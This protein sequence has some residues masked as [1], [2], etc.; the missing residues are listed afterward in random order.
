MS[1]HGQLLHRAADLRDRAGSVVPANRR[2]L[3]VHPAGLAV[4]AD[5]P[6]P[7][8]GHDDLHR[9]RCADRGRDSD[10]ADRAADQRRQ[11]DDLLQLGQH[12][13]RHL[14]DRRDVR[15]RLLPGHRSG[16][17]PEPRP[18]GRG[19][20]APRGQA[21]RRDDQED[22]DRHGL[23]GQPGLARRTIRLDVPGQLR[24][25]LRARRAEADPRGQRR[26]RVRAEVRH[27]G[28]A[29]PGPD[30]R[31]T[32]LAGGGDRGDPGREP[33]GGG[34]Q[35]R[36]PAGPAGPGFRVPDP[37]QGAA[38]HRRRIRG[39]HRPPPRRRLDRP[40]ARRRPDRARLGE[41][42]HR[43]L[44]QRQAG[45]HAAGL[46]VLRRQRAQHRPPG[47]RG[48]GPAQ[49][50]FPRRARVHDRLRHDQVRPREHRRGAGDPVRGVPAGVAGRLHLPPGRCA[51][52]S[53]RCWPSRSRSWR[54]SR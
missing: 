48:H 12:E 13:Q 33:P 16:G 31:A 42:R 17:H 45:R 22:V 36:R 30:G 11:G 49:E 51:R 3:P 32:H 35:D 15:G 26:E 53:S 6:G 37:H 18:D 41:L 43:G 47:P 46:P 25:D 9:R 7:G 27:A 40:P 39:H 52:R 21:V 1:R 14:D 4:S 34:G 5:H 50:E 38:L 8:P 19:G 2:H 10:D 24:P 29:R 28:L 54:R 44:A 23:R 20:A